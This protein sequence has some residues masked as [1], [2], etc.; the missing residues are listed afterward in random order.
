MMREILI[1]EIPEGKGGEPRLTHPQRLEAMGQDVGHRIVDRLA[2]KQKFIGFDDLDYVKFI[3]RDFWEALFGKK[4]DKLQTNKRGTYVISDMEFKWIEKYTTSTGGGGGAQEIDASTMTAVV[5]LLHFTC[6][7]IRGA[8]TNLG[9][10][11]TVTH[12][13]GPAR[14]P[15]V[16]FNVRRMTATADFKL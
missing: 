9:M 4:V 16:V 7:I 12:E 11:A 14:L 1:Y 13:V 2:E 5:K 10:P 3:C 6:G 8:L 15:G